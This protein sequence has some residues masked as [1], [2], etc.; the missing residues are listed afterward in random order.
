[1]SLSDNLREY[2]SACFTGLWVESHEHPDALTEM[3]ELCREETWRLA[4]WDIEQGLQIPGQETTESGGSDPLAAIR[5]INALASP[6]SS[7]IL[8][9]QNFHKFLN[10][11]EIIQAV[12]R[13][14][15]EGWYGCRLDQ[16]EHQFTDVW[17]QYR[18]CEHP[19]KD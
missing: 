11:P 10:S 15:I 2:I 14:V 17:R 8:V 19:W 4:T 18:E 16:H 12:A 7:A 6:E 13:Q 5:S 1:M 3:A 9:L